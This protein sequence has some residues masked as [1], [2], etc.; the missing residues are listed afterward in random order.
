MNRRQD[1]PFTSRNEF[2]FIASH[3]YEFGSLIFEGIGMLLCEEMLSQE[4]L[5]NESKD[6]ILK[7]M[8]ERQ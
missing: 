5:V 2:S 7:L 1:L 6:S 8:A 3:F 4:C